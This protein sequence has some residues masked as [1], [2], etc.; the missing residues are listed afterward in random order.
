ML[1]IPKTPGSMGWKMDKPYLRN[2]HHQKI[3]ASSHLRNNFSDNGFTFFTYGEVISEDIQ[4]RLQCT[5]PWMLEQ[6]EHGC[7]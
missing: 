6:G 4:P 2:P 3:T 7:S 1:I 5:R